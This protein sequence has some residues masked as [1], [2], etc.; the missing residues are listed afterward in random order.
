[1]QPSD[2]AKLLCICVLGA[3]YLQK[4]NTFKYCLMNI[5]ILAE[6][7]INFLSSDR[8]DHSCASKCLQM[9][10]HDNDDDN[11]NDDDLNDDHND[12][13]EGSRPKHTQA[14][15]PSEVCQGRFE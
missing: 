13:D 14:A 9:K 15:K 12:N 3:W 1:M 4:L 7:G 10:T 11:D 2:R 5:L 6:R 8:S